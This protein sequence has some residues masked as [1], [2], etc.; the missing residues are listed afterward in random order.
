MINNLCIDN[1]VETAFNLRRVFKKFVSEQ[2]RP[3]MATQVAPEEDKDNESKTLGD[4][5]LSI[6]KQYENLRF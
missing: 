1:K 3:G 4:Q 2:S 6:E 5:P